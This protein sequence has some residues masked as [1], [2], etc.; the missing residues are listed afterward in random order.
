M[1]VRA[2]LAVLALASISFF[3]FPGHTILQSDTQVYIPILQHLE[4][5]DVLANDLM[6]VRPHV[7]YSLYDEIAL[8]LRKL[9]GAS[10][11]TLLLLQQFVVRAVGVWGLY[12]F[13]TGLGFGAIPSV[14][15]AALCSLGAPVMGPMVLTVEY[16]P[17]PR[18]FAMPFLLLSMGALAHGRTVLAAAA[19]TVGFAMHP[20][21]VLSYCGILGV[22]LLWR[23]DWKAVGALLAGPAL[24]LL[25]L[26][27]QPP[28]PE[29][30][31][32]FATIPPALEKLQRMRAPYNWVSLWIE[33]WWKH[34]ALLTALLA[35]AF[36]R[37]RDLVP[38]TLRAILVALPALAWVSLP[39][40]YF[41]LERMK[42]AF[43]P[44]YQPA[45][46][47][48]FLTLFVIVTC[49]AAAVWAG[50]CKRYVEAAAFA[51]VPLALA[52]DT[53][54]SI[55]GGLAIVMALAM[56][57]RPAALAAAFL[58]ALVFPIWKQAPSP[59][60]Q[61]LNELASWARTQTATD[62]VFQFADA[63]RQ[64]TPGIFRAR[65]QRALYADWKSGGQAN[66]LPA[67]AHEWG[68]RWKQVE[69][70]QPLERYRSL[71]IDYVVFSAARAPNDVEPVFSNSRWAVFR[72]DGARTRPAYAP[73]RR[74]AR[75]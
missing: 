48:L 43:I 35:A 23:R 11:E 15:F 70:V 51:T 38:S 37:M 67:F 2:A 66:F 33:L 71:G 5:P 1:T 59:H 63:G 46:H 68:L 20:P 24:V 29:R 28:S 34:Y 42:W 17:I 49:A 22:V 8:T 27:G 65:A 54:L 75:L 14:M 39:L 40:S 32:L 64:V 30:P 74:T 12:L 72:L 55:A 13:G 9:T 18:G 73:F 6:A 69:K 44:Q 58:P 47:L 61:E 57:Y 41:A 36:F 60:S 4:N 52:Q 25:T 53:H 50:I 16:E 45:R 10:F 26:L 3:W 62:A 7:S 31:A 56:A 21:T 19:A